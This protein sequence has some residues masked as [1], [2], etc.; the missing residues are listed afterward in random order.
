[1]TNRA[2]EYDRDK[3]P[4]PNHIDTRGW[5]L[6]FYDIYITPWEVFSSRIQRVVQCRIWNHNIKITSPTSLTTKCTPSTAN[7]YYATI[8]LLIYPFKSILGC[9]AIISCD[10]LTILQAPLKCF[11]RIAKINTSHLMG[12]VQ[13]TIPLHKCQTLCE[14]KKNVESVECPAKYH[15]FSSIYSSH[16]ISVAGFA[17]HFRIQ[18]LPL[19]THVL[20][21]VLTNEVMGM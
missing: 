3:R 11:A 15:F 9:L 21:N 16:F 1:M 14:I 7:G 2:N 17:V 13:Q 6:G 20:T 19:L 5:F 8:L 12:S 10:I 18:S 4:F